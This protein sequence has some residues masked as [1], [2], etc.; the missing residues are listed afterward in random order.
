MPKFVVLCSLVIAVCSTAV[1]QASNDILIRVADTATDTYGYRN[2]MGKMVI[3]F[4]KYLYCF[5]DTFRN[6]AIVQQE[7]RGI[8]GIDRQFQ[9]LYGVYIFDNGPDY[10][11]DGLFRIKTDGK[12]GY[13]DSSTGKVVIKLQFACAWPFENGVAK[14][15]MHC[16]T[17]FEG[18]HS[19]WISDEWFYINKE[20]VRVK[21]PVK[22]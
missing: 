12:I 17:R 4:G 9:I 18:E 20:G 19:T 6:Y 10:P 22:R 21:S 11:A 16:Q 7:G 13:A 1:G 2:E 5:T 8:I 14:V 15:A 3:P